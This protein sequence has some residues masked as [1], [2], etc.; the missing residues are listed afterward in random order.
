MD[1]RHFRDAVQGYYDWHIHL[2]S[3]HYNMLTQSATEAHGSILYLAMNVWTT[4]AFSSSTFDNNFLKISCDF[5]SFL[6]VLFAFLQATK[7]YS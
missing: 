2:L 4:F 3:Y 6:G 5:H 1:E 7:M